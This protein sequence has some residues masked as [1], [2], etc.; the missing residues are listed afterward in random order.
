MRSPCFLTLLILAVLSLSS[1]LRR[2]HE[3]ILVAGPVDD[4]PS[5]VAQLQP[6]NVGR[7]TTSILRISVPD[8]EQ[9]V[10]VIRTSRGFQVSINFCP[11]SREQQEARLLALARTFASAEI[12]GEGWG[13]IR[14]AGFRFFGFSSAFDASAF[15]SNALNDVLGVTKVDYSIEETTLKS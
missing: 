11:E 12:G 5:Y 10:E 7:K 6:L 15:L 8:S 3:P 13:K 9:F 4:L 2:H 1:C 14:C